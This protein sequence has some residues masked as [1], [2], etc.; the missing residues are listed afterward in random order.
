MKPVFILPS[1]DADLSEIHDWIANDDLRAADRLVDR[2]VEATRRLKDF[3]DRGTP[4]PELS[5]AARSLVVGN[6]LILYRV[7]PE[8]VDIVRI[9][10]GARDLSDLA[11]D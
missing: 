11:W 5:D 9:V 3:P 10:H 8:R 6:Y 7:G 1:A 4:R 2:L